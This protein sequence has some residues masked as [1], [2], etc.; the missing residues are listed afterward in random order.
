MLIRYLESSDDYWLKDGVVITSE[1]T[2]N[3]TETINILKSVTNVFIE[4]K[5]GF[6]TV[7]DIIYI[8]PKNGTIPCIDVLLK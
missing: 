3:P 8:V 6:M 7:D 4:E 1:K 2:D 5:N